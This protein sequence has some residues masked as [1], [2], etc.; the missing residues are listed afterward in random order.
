MVDRRGTAPRATILQGSS[1][2]LCAARAL[3]WFRSTLSCSSSRRFH[4]ISLQGELERPVGYDPTS[5]AWQA[6]TLPLSYVPRGGQ[7]TDS[8]LRT[9]KGTA[10]TAPLLWPLAY[11]PELV[12]EVGIEPTLPRGTSL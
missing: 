10:F 9:L 4:Q 1:A 12:A 2:P 6:E 5:S 3:S 8:N 7:G 11:L